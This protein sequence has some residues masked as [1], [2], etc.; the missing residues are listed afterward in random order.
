MGALH[1]GFV[2]QAQERSETGFAPEQEERRGAGLAPEQK[3]RCEGRR[4]YCLEGCPI[5]RAHCP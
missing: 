2:A 4:D 3:E 5:A 1:L